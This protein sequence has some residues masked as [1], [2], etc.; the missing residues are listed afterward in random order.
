[1]L[2]EK[3]MKKIRWL[4]CLITLLFTIGGGMLVNK[5]AT[6][7]DT[8]IHFWAHTLTLHINGYE[9]VLEEL[10]YPKYPDIKI[11]V[12]P[13]P[14]LSMKIK[15][16]LASGA[17]PALV[18]VH[19]TLGYEL[20]LKGQLERLDPDV[21]ASYEWVKENLWPENYKQGYDEHIYLVG[22]PDPIGDTGII[23]NVDMLKEV[24]L[25][26]P[27][28]FKDM[29]ETLMYAEKLTKYDSRDNVIRG[30]LNVREGNNPVMFWSW[31]VEQGGKF[32]DNDTQEFNFNTPEAK[33]AMGWFYDL[34][35]KYKVTSTDLPSAFLALSQQLSAMAYMWP[36]YAYF[37][38]T[39]YPELNFAL[40]IRSPFYTAKAPMFCHTDTWN[41]AVP[42][43]LS[44]EKR[45]AA[46]EYLR[47]INT[48]EAQK[49]LLE[50]N[51]GISPWKVL[52]DP[53]SDF[54]LKGKGMFVRE[55]LQYL[56]NARYYGPFGNGDVLQYDICWPIMED[57][58]I[59]TLTV[60]EGLKQMTE[61]MN[62]ELREFRE[63]YPYV[64]KTV[65]DWGF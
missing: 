32:F 24:G 53:N 50:E 39:V 52:A 34:V 55:T 10:F 9:R 11:L 48:V 5:P 12:E 33:K 23:A 15:T 21:V 19:G 61:E 40:I 1:M 25:D 59:E 6:G 35:Y 42:K 38:K 60:E 58:L 45:E 43:G 22:I 44:E 65:I 14:S 29:D 16:G 3:R 49:I 28:K 47:I 46:F 26:V 2:E 63:K 31:I 62:S 8:T 51:P 64:P 36:E 7:Q 30:G 18:S 37:S 13:Q 4:A 20:A 27:T 17:V 41:I 56:A 54:Y 57:I